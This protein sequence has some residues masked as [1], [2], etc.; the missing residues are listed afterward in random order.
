M[1][2]ERMTELTTFLLR[3]ALGLTFIARKGAA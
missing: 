2:Q 3:V 1:T